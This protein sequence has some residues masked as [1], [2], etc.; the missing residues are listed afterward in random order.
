MRYAKGHKGATRKRIVEVASKRFRREGVAAVGVASLMSDAGLTRGGFYA[1]FGSKEEL[2]R[3]AVKSALDR[4]REELG[5]AATADGGG[6]EAILRV[7]LGLRYRDRPERGCAAASLA[8]EIARHSHSTRAAFTQE[9]DAIIEVIVQQLPAGDR[10]VRRQAAIAI[11]GMMMGTL[12]LARAVPN[13]NLSNQILE[14]GID[15]ALILG[16][17]ASPSD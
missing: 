9:F 15:A 6:L 4:M 14:S 10:G 7:Y 11:F 8:P 12:Q 13:T 3:E 5:R 2:F 1:H 17:E 16:R